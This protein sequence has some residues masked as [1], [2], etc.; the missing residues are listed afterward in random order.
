MRA[1]GDSYNVLWR[2]NKESLMSTKL[3]YYIISYYH[4]T[5]QPCLC[6]CIKQTHELICIES[7]NKRIMFLHNK[8]TNSK[9]FF[10]GIYLVYIARLNFI[11]Y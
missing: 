8:I 1:K 7:N 6:N 5:V 11:N 10:C 2:K 9:S 4:T 3:K